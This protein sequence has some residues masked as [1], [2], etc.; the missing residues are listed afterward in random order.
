MRPEGP[1]GDRGGDRVRGVVEAVD[2]VEDDGQRDDDEQSEREPLEHVGRHLLHG[3]GRL[4]L[5]GAG[6]H[7]QAGC[8][9]IRAGVPRDVRSRYQQRR[10]PRGRPG[11]ASAGRSPSPAILPRMRLS[12]LFFATLR[13]DPAD[14]EMPSHRLLVRAGLRPPARIGHLLAPA[15]RLPG[16]QARR[17]GH[18]R[19]D[20]RD[21]LPGDG[22]A[23]RPPG[24]PLARVGSL[25]RDRSGDGPVQGP[26]RPRHGPRHD[27][28]G[29]RGR[30]P[31]RHR[32]ARIASCRSW[33][34][35]SRRS[36]ATS[37]APVAA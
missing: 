13:D 18:P 3:R 33:S 28:R 23:G 12:Q 30:P 4:R 6:G 24:R 37:P 7:R 31:G 17:A 9:R 2:V 22:D 34:T 16:H 36:S 26:R 27:P 32:A 29:G 14:A 25:R 8:P 1:G 35:T 19:G 21:R 5:G 15:A 20:G 11:A 10:A